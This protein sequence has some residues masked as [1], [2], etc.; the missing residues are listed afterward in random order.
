MVGS[1]VLPDHNREQGTGNREQG[2]ESKAGLSGT[3]WQ[4]AMDEDPGAKKRV[5]EKEKAQPV[6][7]AFVLR[8]KM[9]Y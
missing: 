6:G 2:S 4:N 1:C 5:S 3:E 9:Y 7:W 8:V